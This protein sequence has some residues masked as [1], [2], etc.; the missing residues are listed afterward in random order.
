MF[1]GYKPKSWVGSSGEPRGLR[2]NGRPNP[3]EDIEPVPYRKSDSVSS[4]IH[5]LADVDDGLNEVSY[6]KVGLERSRI[7]DFL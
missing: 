2:C 5:L 4:P 1:R 3:G 6:Q 7:F